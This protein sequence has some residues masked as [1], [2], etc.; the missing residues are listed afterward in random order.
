MSHARSLLTVTTCV[1]LLTLAGCD[2]AAPG[3]TADLDAAAHAT[4]QRSHAENLGRGGLAAARRATAGYQR[5][6]RAMAAGW[7]VVVSPCVEVPGLGGMGYHYL[8]PA[9]ADGTADASA[10]EILLY[11][12]QKNGRLRLVGVEYVV[13]FEYEPREADG[14][15]PPE[16][17]GRAFSESEDADG[18]ALHAWIWRHNPAGMFADFNPNVSCEH[19]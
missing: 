4:A 1:L 18:W 19:D 10:P 12:P 8:N 7:S 13:P 14:G 11:E 16:L 2:P 5:V 6:D 15:T 9:L 17:F 3:A